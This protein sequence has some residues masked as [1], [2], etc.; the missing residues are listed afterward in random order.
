MMRMAVCLI[1][2][3]LEVAV[4]ISTYLPGSPFVSNGWVIPSSVVIALP[5]FGWAVIERAADKAKSP[6]RKWNDFSG[7]TD[8]DYN[9]Q[10]ADLGSFL[11]C[12]WQAVA[13]GIPAL[14]L[15]WAVMMISITS[16]TGQPVRQGKLYYLT[17]HGDRT[18][19]N[20]AAYEEAVRQE[21]RTFASGSAMFLL[22]A[23]FAT[24]TY[25]PG[26]DAQSTST[27]SPTG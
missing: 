6:K 26:R 12:H 27:P 5:F 9:K 11:K 25:R 13:F 16:S 21:E 17:D 8:A 18:Y 23:A 2:A 7:V 22:V 3:G 4:V 14:A 1:A 15:L 24:A 19:V 20:R 10:W